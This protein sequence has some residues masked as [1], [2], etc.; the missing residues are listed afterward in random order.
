M[1]QAEKLWA[2]GCMVM[3]AAAAIA[4]EKPLRIYLPQEVRLDTASVELGRVGI[5]LG[6]PALVEKAQAVQL[7]AFA[8]EGQALWVDRGTILSRLASSGIT[9]RQV[10]FLGAE[11]VRIG[12][13]EMILPADRI[14]ACA[15]RYLEGKLADVNGAVATVLRPPQPRVLGT[16]AGAAELTV[17]NDVQQ[18]GGVRKISVAI[19]Q[20]G[21][22]VCCEEV[23]F[24][25]RCQSRRVVAVNELA[26]G[27]TLTSEN[28]RVETVS[29]ETPEP[30][31]WVVPYGMVTRQ[32]VAAGAAV[33]EAQLEPKQEPILV[34]RRQN[35]MVRI[36][37]GSLFIT[38]HGEAMDDGRVGEIIR[39]RRG[40]RPQE[41]IIVCRIQ[42]DGSAEPVL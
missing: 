26:P 16:D 12:R 20:D 32:R 28:V 41:R 35:V 30:A 37:T 24:S 17:K 39:I 25:V 10:Q 4:A 3:G 9:P 14:V 2:I 42:A 6:D 15:Q 1:K 23:Y 33:S 31:G 18:G 21:K 27:T 36:D 19:L 34:R 8:V 29:T 11:K 13:H 5:L 40:E 7:G 38:A 22:E